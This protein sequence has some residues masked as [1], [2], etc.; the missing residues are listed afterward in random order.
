MVESGQDSA[1]ESL[2]EL[3]PSEQIVG[4]FRVYRQVA[5]Q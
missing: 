2:L 4:R 1:H 3:F 5:S